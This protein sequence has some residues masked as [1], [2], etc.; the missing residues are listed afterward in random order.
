MSVTLSSEQ[1][2]QVENLAYHLIKLGT[3]MN[4]GAKNN[5]A[6]APA[7]LVEMTGVEMIESASEIASIVLG[8]SAT[9]NLL[10]DVQRDIEQMEA[11][12]EEIKASGK[13]PIEFMLDNL[14][15][16]GYDIEV[17]WPDDLGYDDC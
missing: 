1:L 8:T 11:L 17:E 15:E 3:S 4:S 6:D 16:S 7:F 10:A 9:A 13:N 12:I 5:T 14:E 2:E